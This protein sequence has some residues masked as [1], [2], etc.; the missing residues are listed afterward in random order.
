L[1]SEDEHVVYS[2]IA[3]L[4]SVRDYPL[5]IDLLKSGNI[6]VSARVAD[7]AM[8]LLF[9]EKN[10]LLE[11]LAE[12]DIVT[13]LARLKPLDELNGHWIEEFLAFASKAFANACADFFVERVEHAAK[14]Q[15]WNH[16]PCNHGP[17]CNVPLRF[18]E[19]P[20]FS[21]LLVRVSH[22]MSSYPEQSGLFRIRAGELFNAMFSSGGNEGRSD[23]S[24]AK[25]DGELII[26]LRDWVERADEAGLEVIGQVLREGPRDLPFRERTLALRY[27]ERCNQLG[28][29]C[30]KGARGQLL[31]AALS[32]TRSGTPGEPFP[33]DIRL[34]DDATEALKSI[35]RFAPGRDFYEDLLSYA[36][37]SIRQQLKEAETFEE[38]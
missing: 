15:N 30:Y 23:G 35:P 36:E 6:R 34:R 29:K 14:T 37:H 4:R 19:A 32:G 18:R 25:F 1:K 22:W 26:F 9:S 2:G 10:E 5:V 24:A 38:E 7:D 3:A 17:Y 27:L 31:A 20:E 11:D 21:R 16:R 28:A 13:F 33:E 12:D 8:A